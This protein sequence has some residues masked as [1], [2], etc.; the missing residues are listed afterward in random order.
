MYANPIVAWAL[1]FNCGEVTYFAHFIV[2]WL[3]PF[4]AFIAAEHCF[5]QQTKGTEIE[6]R[7]E[8]AA[9]ETETEKTK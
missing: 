7:E 6:D 3:A 2:Y 9:T 5:G 4:S 1:T 8:K